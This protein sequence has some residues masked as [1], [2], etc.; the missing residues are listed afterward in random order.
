VEPPAGS[1]TG[2]VS[3]EP[4]ATPVEGADP[5]TGGSVPTLRL[6][7]KWARKRLKKDEDSFLLPV[8]AEINVI[9]MEYGPIDFWIDEKTY[10][11]LLDEEDMKKISKHLKNLRYVVIERIAS[12]GDENRVRLLEI[13]EDDDL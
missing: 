12:D 13:I 10:T 4:S 2:G 3:L 1:T 6:F 7:K 8:Q 9:P 11:Y 5:E